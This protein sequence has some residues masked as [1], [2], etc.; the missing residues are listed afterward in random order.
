[1]IAPHIIINERNSG[2]EVSVGI[3]HMTFDII[4]SSG[5]VPKQISYEIEIILECDKIIKILSQSRT[6]N[7]NQTK[8]FRFQ[9]IIHF[10][11]TVLIF[12]T[13]FIEKLFRFWTFRNLLI[14]I[15]KSEIWSAVHRNVIW[16]HRFI[17]A[18]HPWKQTYVFRI[19]NIVEFL[20]YQ[21]VSSSC[22]IF[23]VS[24]ARFYSLITTIL[25]FLNSVW[26]QVSG[27]VLTVQSWP[28]AVLLTVVVIQHSQS[29]VRI[30]QVHWRICNR[31]NR[32]YQP[33]RES[34]HHINH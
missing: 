33:T 19:V 28:I 14:S 21:S 27:V 31:T 23:L 30:I 26:I 4:L 17:F 18:K 32:N 20:S 2:N 11:G 3:F 1:M 12:L 13:K 5:I 24:I 25:I 16:H 7:I 29:V 8:L 22:R 15:I 6:L 10:D 34:D 9:I